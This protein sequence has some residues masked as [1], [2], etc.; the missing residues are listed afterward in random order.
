MNITQDFR[1]LI[2]KLDVNQN[3]NIIVNGY[4]TT[5]LYDAI[6]YTELTVN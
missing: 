2:T 1:N 5:L 3:T 6:R 4:N